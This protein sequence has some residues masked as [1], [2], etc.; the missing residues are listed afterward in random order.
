M[1]ASAF[2]SPGS[3]HHRFAGG[4]CLL[5]LSPWAT[6]ADLIVVTNSRYPVTAPADARVIELDRAARLEADLAAN[7]P[8]DPSR[9]AAMMQQRLRDGGERLQHELA[10]AYQG[11][12]DAWSLGV[13]TLPAVVVDRRYVVYGETD[14]TKAVA[15]IEAYRR[16][17]P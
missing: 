11:V 3:R 7:L 10:A 8:V 12:A 14:V 9:A 16:A 4:L 5:L 13:T 17:Q 6:A 15:R 1:A 2:H